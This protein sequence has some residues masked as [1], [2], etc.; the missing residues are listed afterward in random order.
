MKGGVPGWMETS[1]PTKD[2]D[3]REHFLGVGRVVPALVLSHS[4]ELDKE[5]RGKRRVTVAPIA[6]ISSV[7]DSAVQEAILAQSIT[8]SMPLPEIPGLGTCYADLRSMTTLDRRI[9]DAGKRLA[10]M[11]PEAERR[12]QAQLVAFL[13]RLDLPPPAE[14]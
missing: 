2:R 9:V 1:A 3:G 13:V 7:S 14:R 8:A 5:D 10:S 11:T 6:P 4:C 12:L